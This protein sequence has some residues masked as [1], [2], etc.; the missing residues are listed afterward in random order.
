MMTMENPPGNAPADAV[1]PPTVDASAPPPGA[2]RR[3]LVMVACVVTGMFLLLYL[4]GRGKTSTLGAFTRRINVRLQQIERGP[5]Y[6]NVAPGWIVARGEGVFEIL[7]LAEIWREY[8]ADRLD[9]DVAAQ[10]VATAVTLAK[11]FDAALPELAEAAHRVEM[12]PIGRRAISPAL[13]QEQS[14]SQYV[15][16]RGP[17]GLPLYLCME[18]AVEDRGST[19]TIMRPLLRDQMRRFRPQTGQP[20]L[21][22]SALERVG[23]ATF[24][25]E[26][27]PE[28]G[29]EP[30]HWRV[31]VAGDDAPSP[32]AMVGG[33]DF[34]RRAGLLL[35]KATGT[36]PV[37]EFE[38]VCHSRTAVYLRAGSHPGRSDWYLRFGAVDSDA[39]A[40]FYNAA[41]V[42]PGLLD[43]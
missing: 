20:G 31:T 18:L 14:A 43:R 10:Q 1:N 34:A 17:Q 42:E 2:R 36:A 28:L 5:L 11:T 35:E 7:D 26:P 25:L 30:K 24:T 13:T 29:E 9:L 38:V 3:Y 16:R 19:R 40:I 39:P 12:L 21:A 23:Q 4:P 27:A 6:T 37:A 41:G 15:I 33:S 8:Q 22:E 32:L